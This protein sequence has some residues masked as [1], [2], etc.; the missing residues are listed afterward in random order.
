VRAGGGG[1]SPEDYALVAFSQFW[2][3]RDEGRLL[4]TAAAM[5]RDGVRL[6]SATGHALLHVYAARRLWREALGVV[7]E[8]LELR[9]EEGRGTFGG[10]DERE[11][12]GWASSSAASAASRAASFGAAGDGVWHVALRELPRHAAPDDVVAAF[13]ERMSAGQRARFAA[14]YGLRRT[15]AGGWAL[16]RPSDEYDEGEEEGRADDDD[17]DERA[18]ETAAPATTT[19]TTAP[20]LPI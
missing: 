13:A 5:R 18:A 20:P 4:E 15:S 12:E 1:L 11:G 3:H 10:E 7:D 14:M 9:D 19:A 8:L 16:A 17:D 2:V 6:D